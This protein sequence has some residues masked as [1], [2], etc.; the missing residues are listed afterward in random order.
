[1]TKTTTE[2]LGTGDIDKRLEER[3]IDGILVWTMNETE[4]ELVL[5]IVYL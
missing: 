4:D 3:L 5:L 2:N 1:M